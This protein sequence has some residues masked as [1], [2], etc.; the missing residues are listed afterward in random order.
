MN[1]G[2]ITALRFFAEFILSKTKELQFLHFVQRLAE[3]VLSGEILPL[4]SAQS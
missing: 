4:R 2:A 1:L 3:L